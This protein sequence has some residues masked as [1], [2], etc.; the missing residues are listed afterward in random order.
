MPWCLVG[1]S[2]WAAYFFSAVE[3]LRTNNHAERIANVMTTIG[4][5]QERRTV[6][7]VKKRGWWPSDQPDRPK[8]R[9]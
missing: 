3:H 2:Y 6:R 7:G 9:F 5:V 1:G 4:F 8:R